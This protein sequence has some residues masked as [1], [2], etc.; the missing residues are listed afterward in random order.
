[1]QIPVNKELLERYT[2]SAPR[3]T[4]YPTAIDW[5]ADSFNPADYAQHL[6][7]AATA[8]TDPLSVYIHIPFCAEMCL[9]CGCNVV[10]TR[11]EERV[12]RYLDQLEAEFERV[13]ATGIGMRPVHQYHWGGGTPTHLT[14]EQ[15]RRVHGM[16]AKIFTLTPD[17][18]VAI[19]VD[20]RVTTR[21]Q[22]EVLTELGFNR[23]SMGVQDFDHKVQEAVKRIQ[24]KEI[25]VRL[26]HD[27]RELGMKS[28]N[29][30]LIYGL[31]HQSRSL[32]A[33]TVQE[34]L[35]LRPERVALFH[36]AHVPWLKKHQTAMD[37]DAAPTSEEKV[38]IFLASVKAFQDAGYEYL[39]L[40][41]FALPDDELAVALKNRTLHR[42]FMGYTTH[43][44][45]EMVSFGVSS[46][47]EVD[48]CF[49]QNH[50]AEVDY[51]EAIEKGELAAL[52]GHKMSPEDC[53]RRD[54]ILGL[55]CNG[56]LDKQPIETRHQIVFDEHF[57]KQLKALAPMQEDGLVRLHTNAIEL[58][59]MG[60]MF[61]RNVAVQ[62]DSYFAARQEQGETGEG[63]FSKT[64]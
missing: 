20:P 45:G 24:P 29:L 1:M 5:V 13:G 35:A 12:E 40:D 2:T 58:T 28:V 18:E 32:F 61:M 39:G 25:T 31:P 64:L 21:E 47:S 10:I 17:A 9:Y 51:L 7:N 3:Y 37:M 30:D 50:H 44:G 8:S 52:R 19:E 43:T 23:I 36:Y 33:E 60:Q 54:V 4:S 15:I 56:W 11:R 22:L 63:T 34:T 26:V 57:A 49:V 38:E 48:G 62:F 6:A 59:S 42:N 55:M 53:L 16:F 41:H 27:A 14:C 46:I